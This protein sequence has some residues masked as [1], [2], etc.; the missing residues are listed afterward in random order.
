VARAELSLEQARRVAIAAQAFGPRS[1]A[2]PGAA[3][4]MRAIRRLGALQID[5]VNVL[6]RSH[7]LP[8]FSRLG[9]YS[10]PLFERLAYGGARR[11]LFEYWGHEASLLPLELYPLFEWRRERAR[12]GEGTWGSIA[13]V[14]REQ[15]ELV[16]A[17]E[18]QIEERG[19]LGAG[20]LDGYRRTGEPWWGWNDHKRAIEYLFWSGRVTTATRRN[21]ERIYDLV[22]RVLPSELLARRAG[23]AAGQRRELV[24]IAAAALGVAGERDL[25]D[26]FRLSPAD[27]RAAARELVEAGELLPVRL[28]GAR[29]PYYLSKD[30]RVPRSIEAAAL[31][32]P[33]DSLI[34]ERRRT[35]ALFGFRF[36]LEIYTPAHKRVHGYYVLPFLL[37]DRIVARVDLKSDRAAAALQ[38]R[39]L[40]VEPGVSRRSAL[41]PLRAELERLAAWLE[42]DRVAGFAA[43]ARAGT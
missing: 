9:P 5:S 35:E 37:N 20:D 19:P 18:R 32:S 43:A 36:R 12:S 17:V 24:R 26:Y 39:A 11:T 41:T 6:V 34:W 1:E 28:E 30:A 22:E 10:R 25:R 8:L 7:Y 16:R 4:L 29:E 42:L 14:A 2:A 33:F 38:V 13:R 27:G 23:D 31:L 40:H 3:V 15:P 21:F